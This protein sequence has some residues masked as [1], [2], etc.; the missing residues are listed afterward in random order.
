MEGYHVELGAGDRMEI[1]PMDLVVSL[2]HCQKFLFFSV[3]PI[4]SF[5]SS[6]HCIYHMQFSD[7]I[8]SQLVTLLLI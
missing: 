2:R 4:K 5:H 7:S 8:P 1:G 3:V 6:T